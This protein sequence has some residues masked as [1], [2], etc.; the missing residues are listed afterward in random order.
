[1]SSTVGFFVSFR[2]NSLDDKVRFDRVIIS[3]L[4]H[5]CYC[6]KFLVFLILCFYGLYC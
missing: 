2:V 1:M 6:L 3:N 5:Q 4:V